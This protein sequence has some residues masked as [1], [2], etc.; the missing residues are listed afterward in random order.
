MSP[1]PER[2]AMYDALR[3]ATRDLPQDSSFSIN[4]TELA[5]LQR[6]RPEDLRARGFGD[7]YAEE[8]CAELFRGRVGS[9]GSLMRIKLTVDPNAPPLI[10][11]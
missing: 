7:E 1:G 9:L 2:A 6:L 10:P 5:D 11:G 4:P 3:L 8:A